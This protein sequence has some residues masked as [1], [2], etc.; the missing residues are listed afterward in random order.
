MNTDARYFNP[1]VSY[2][3]DDEIRK[4]TYSILNLTKDNVVEGEDRIPQSVL[5]NAKGIV[6][7]TIFKLG[8]MLTGRAGT[9]LVICRLD[10]GSW[11]APSA[12]GLSGRI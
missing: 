8:F 6:F 7:L 2:S 12:I 9:G 11:S 4:A 5:L 10:D 3:L 1:A